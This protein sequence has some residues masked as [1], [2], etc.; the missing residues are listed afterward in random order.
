MDIPTQWPAGRGAQQEAWEPPRTVTGRDPHR[1]ARLRALG[2]AV[3]PAQA[4]EIGRLIVASI[5]GAP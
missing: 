2:N 1:R 3:V 4:R 5:G